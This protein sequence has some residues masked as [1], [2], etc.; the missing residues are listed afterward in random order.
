MAGVDPPSRTKGP[1]LP[2]AST[3]IPSLNHSFILFIFNPFT[4]LAHTH[5]PQMAILIPAYYAVLSAS[6]IALLSFCCAELN[7]PLFNRA[8][9]S[10]QRTARI[11]YL[12]PRPRG[13][14]GRASHV[15]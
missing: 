13:P 5:I 1:L 7:A 14:F 9:V 3:S 4:Q 6:N 15:D 12:F 2:S 8:R 11:P 10:L